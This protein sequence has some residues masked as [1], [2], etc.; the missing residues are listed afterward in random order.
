M[1]V[2]ECV[3]VCV[4]VYTYM[5]YT[6]FVESILG[7]VPADDQFGMVPVH[8]YQPNVNWNRVRERKRGRRGREREDSP[9]QENP[10]AN[11]RRMSLKRQRQWMRPL[12]WMV[13]SLKGALGFSSRERRTK[14]R[15]K[16]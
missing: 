13:A 4:C 10:G 1:D 7:F 5:C 8:I 2:R 14:T 3:C 16:G 9:N 12:P 6:R 15:S 11:L